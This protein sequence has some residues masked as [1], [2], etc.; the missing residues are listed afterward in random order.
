[1]A[2]P[3]GHMKMALAFDD[4]RVSVLV[5]DGQEQEEE[6]VDGAEHAHDPVEPLEVVVVQAG[7]L[8]PRPVVAAP[9]RAVDDGHQH[10]AEVISQRQRRPRQ[11][12]RQGSHPRRRLAEEELEQ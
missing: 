6:V 3:T 2:T 11:R 1:M 10:R 5:P 7:T 12:R 8:Q 4:P 9:C